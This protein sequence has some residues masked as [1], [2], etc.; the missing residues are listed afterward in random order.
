MLARQVLSHL[1]LLFSPRNG[2]NFILLLLNV[3]KNCGVE[4]F[5]FLTNNFFFLSIS[6]QSGLVSEA[7]LHMPA[8]FWFTLGLEERTGKGST[9]M[10][11]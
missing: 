4:L 2:M 3:L 7:V 6:S 11:G 9:G 10:A 1:S 5:S 8:I